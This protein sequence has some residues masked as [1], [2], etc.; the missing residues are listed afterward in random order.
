MRS[1]GWR[2]IAGLVLFV[3]LP[4]MGL[5]Q[6]GAPAG[7]HDLSGVWSFDT[8]GGPG[9]AGNLVGKD[10]TMTPWGQDKFKANQ[11]T[12]QTTTYD[13]CEPL[14]FT[15]FPAYPHPIEMVQ[16]PGRI[17]IF[18]EVD[19]FWRTIWMDRPVPKKEDLL[20]GPSYL[21]TSVGHWDGDDLVIDT[22]GFNEKTWLDT[23]RHPHSEDMHVTERFHRVAPDTLEYTMT[24]DDPK[25]YSKRFNWGPK[26]LHLK[27]STTWQIQEDFCS[28]TEQ[29]KFRDTLEKNLNAPKELV[30][31]NSSGD[32]MEEGASVYR[33]KRGIPLSKNSFSNRPTLSL[34][35][36]SFS[37]L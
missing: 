11:A 14:G 12:G 30:T 18:H 24:F 4:L 1:V 5:A 31:G 21:G 25:A 37:K 3:S 17:F 7:K 19:H 23:A 34:G 27:D 36:K 15:S 16:V 2:F 6:A 8:E 22:I 28:P 9:V 35:S 33:S 13:N 32:L 26:H 20:F 29:A 10:V